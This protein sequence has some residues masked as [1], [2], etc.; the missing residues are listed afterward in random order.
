MDSMSETGRVK[1]LDTTDE[2]IRALIALDGAG[3]SDVADHIDKPLSTSHNHLSTLAELDF[4]TKRGSEY[5]VSTRF[6]EI[7]TRLRNTNELFT[8]T[9]E[10]IDDL[11]NTYDETVT[12]MIEEDEYG[13][14]YYFARTEDLDLQINTGRRTPLTVTA[15]GKAILASFSD[16]R[17]E[18]IIDRRGLVEMTDNSITSKERLLDEIET[19]RD[20][21]FATSNRESGNGMRGVAVYVDGHRTAPGAI[22]VYGPNSRLGEEKIYDD[23]SKELLQ[24]KETVEMNLNFPGTV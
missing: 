23:I 1:T 4:V 22:M 2:V 10:F 24:I 5:E 17:I 12:L 9:K 16:E 15:G 6:L 3:V 7:G 19:I 20:R 8:E 13:I 11:S 21:G 14:L 18:D